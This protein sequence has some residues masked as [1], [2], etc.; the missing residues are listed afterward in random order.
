MAKVGTNA[1]MGLRIPVFPATVTSIVELSAKRRLPA[2]YP[3]R[4][5][6]DA[7]GLMS[8]GTNRGEWRQRI[9]YYTD[10]ILKGAKPS[11]LPVERP[12]KFEFIVNLKA[13][14]QIGIPFHPTC[15]R[16]G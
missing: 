6:A 3:D 8:Y 10:R 5:F 16:G 7:G 13:A 14:K 1:F 12:T 15:W 9:T 2:I 4:Q 11:D